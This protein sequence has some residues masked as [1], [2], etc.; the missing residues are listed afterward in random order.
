MNNS[1]VKNRLDGRGLT[2]LRPLSIEYDVLGYASASVLFSQG[3]T[4]VLCS[5]TLQSSVPQFLRGQGSGWLR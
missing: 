2:Q 1:S 5:V 3:N 4:K